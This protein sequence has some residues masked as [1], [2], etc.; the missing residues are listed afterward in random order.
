MA[1]HARGTAHWWRIAAIAGVLGAVGLWGALAARPFFALSGQ[2]GATDRPEFT[3][4]L[5]STVVGAI[6]V[7]AL[8]IAAVIAAF[9]DY[10]ASHATH[11]VE[12]TRNSRRPNPA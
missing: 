12:A 3:I 8:V 9:R 4:L 11:K 1:D 6:A 2:S 7:A 10:R 5:I